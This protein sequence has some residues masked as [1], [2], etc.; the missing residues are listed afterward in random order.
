ML[1]TLHREVG[2]FKYTDITGV[3]HRGMLRS[4]RFVYQKGIMRKARVVVPS[5]IQ[6]LD[7]SACTSQKQPHGY[8]MKPELAEYKT[9]PFTKP[10]EHLSITTHT[11]IEIIGRQGVHTPR[12]ETYKQ[13]PRKIPL[14]A[15]SN[16]GDHQHPWPCEHV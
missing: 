15:R 14:A 4:A 9:R 1:Q 6:Y 11:P 8:E 2:L 16:S 10:K 12:K 5:S 3:S 13:G 7:S